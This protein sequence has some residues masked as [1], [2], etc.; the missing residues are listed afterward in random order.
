[1]RDTGSEEAKTSIQGMLDKFL[2]STDSSDLAPVEVK[3]QNAM[4]DP[5][6]VP[7]YVPTGKGA[8]QKKALTH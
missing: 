2:D 7:V 8:G 5:G 4:V 6:P 1:M 3:T